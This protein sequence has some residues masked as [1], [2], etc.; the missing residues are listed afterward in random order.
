MKVLQQTSHVLKEEAKRNQSIAR[1]KYLNDKKQN[2]LKL[3][4]VV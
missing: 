4:E 1:R 3:S 2:E